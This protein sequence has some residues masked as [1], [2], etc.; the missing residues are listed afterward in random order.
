VPH[1]ELPNAPG[2]IGPMLRFPES[3]EILNQLAD[4]LLTRDTPTFTKAERESIAAYVSF[5]NDTRFC[6]ESHAAVA[7]HHMGKQT[8]WPWKQF[9]SKRF[10][11]F[12]TIA[13]YVVDCKVSSRMEVEHAKEEGATDQDIHD[14]VLLVSAFCMY[15]R[16]VT[17]L[18]T[19]QPLPGDPSYQKAGEMLGTLGYRGTIAA[20][21][22]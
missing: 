6:R 5:R 22:R 4:L 11:H 17:G 1:I 14:L 21:K 2:I 3:A 19:E 13:E 9:T 10:Q 16:Y 18:N 15:N 12:K 20:M 7:S 8:N